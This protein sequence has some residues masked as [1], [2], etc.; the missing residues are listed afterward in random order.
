MSD[1]I[2]SLEDSLNFKRP[3]DSF[4]SME[5]ATKLGITPKTAREKCLNA[6]RAGILDRIKHTVHGVSSPPAV[7]YYFDKKPTKSKT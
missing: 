4:T 1:W 3:K 5:L 2:K 6:Y 7:F